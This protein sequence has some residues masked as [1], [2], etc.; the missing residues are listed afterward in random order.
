VAETIVANIKPK[1]SLALDSEYI[2]KG[3]DGYSRIEGHI[4]NDAD[5]GD[6]E[7]VSLT[8]SRSGG[9]IVEIK[10]PTVK[11]GKL[12]AGTTDRFYFAVKLS[13]GSEKL[14][15]IGF[16]I[17]CC[18]TF[19]DEQGKAVFNPLQCR[20]GTP[21]VFH[22]IET[23]PYVYGTALDVDDPTFKGRQKEIQY[24]TDFV[25]HPNRPSQQ[26]IVYGQKRCGKS[27]LAEAVRSNLEKNYADKAF[28]VSFTL[29]HDT[30]MKRTYT[31]A[32]FFYTILKEIEWAVLASPDAEKPSTD[33]PDEE[34]MLASDVPA[35]LFDTAIAR[36]KASMAE[37]PGWQQRRLVVIIDEFTNLYND[38]RS[39]WTSPTVLHNWKSIQETNS[40]S[41]FATIFIGHDIAPKFLNEVSLNTNATAII[42]RYPVG[43][44]DEE[45]ACQLIVDPIRDVDGRSRFDDAA[46]RRILYYTNYNPSYIQRFMKKMVDYINANKRIIVTVQDVEKVAQG[47]ITRQYTDFTSI[48]N[49]D[50]FLNNGL[51]SIYS[52][53]KDSQNEVV[54]R[55]IARLTQ[56]TEFCQL[57]KVKDEVIKLEMN[58]HNRFIMEHLDEI[59][60]DLDVRHVIYRQNNNQEIKIIVG[61]FKEWLIRN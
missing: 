25:M 61:L 54:L 23:Q 52:D 42:E 49:F 53:I 35:R 15:A 6:A 51:L 29:T 40:P 14:D 13:P 9:K 59:L 3:A 31:E 19:R 50:E 4:A 30:S 27:T 46:V 20:L 36:F 56:S 44:L 45:S 28:C 60:A 22:E 5:A 24:L 58:D 26:I 48:D 16:S 1:L 17:T 21:R 7:D 10:Q 41:N 47:F 8:I 39:G 33:F 2:A 12:T 55:I 57:D 18:Y 34:E 38:I 32:D 37:T 43:Y 11:K